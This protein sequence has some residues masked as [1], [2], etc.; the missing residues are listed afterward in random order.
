M[1][2]LLQSTMDLRPSLLLQVDAIHGLVAA[3]PATTS[4]RFAATTLQNLKPSPFYNMEADGEP[5]DKALVLLKFSQRSVGKQILNGFRVVTEQVEDACDASAGARYST[6]ACC[7]PEKTPDFTAAKNS[8]ALAI[9]C[10][11]LPPSKSQHAADLY[12]E[13]ME[14]I[15]D[16]DMEKVVAMV[17]QLQRV[18]T[19]NSGNASTSAEAAWQ[20][21]K[22]RRLQRYPT[23][24]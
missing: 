21:R 18:S 24:A 15:D 10:K 8:C 23:Q 9:I 13:T 5:A 14:P 6:V 19:V 17:K 4:E 11:V 20:Q 7:T 3:G 16:K 1:N 12:I 22:C 2:L